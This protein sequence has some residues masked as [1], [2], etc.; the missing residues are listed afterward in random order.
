MKEMSWLV[1]TII[2]SVAISPSGCALNYDRDEEPP[3]QPT[4]AVSTPTPDVAPT[5]E[6]LITVAEDRSPTVTVGERIF[7]VEVASTPAARQRGLSGRASLA[8]SAGMLFVFESGRTT[9]FWMKDMMIPLDFIWIG[10]GCTVVDVHTDVLPPS[11]ETESLEMLS[12][13]SPARYTLEVNA[14][15]VA[16]L[17]I[18]IADP[19]RFGGLSGAG[20]TC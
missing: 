5:S 7:D 3:A 6:V 17:G 2:F 1:M 13:A 4:S 15:K 14:G 8:D 11:S 18:A 12:S 9:S 16:E 20:L 10:D 19:V